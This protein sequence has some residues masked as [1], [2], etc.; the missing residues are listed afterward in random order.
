M[1]RT[2]RAYFLAWGL[3][4]KLLLVGLLGVAVIMWATAFSSRGSRFWRAQRATTAARQEQDSWLR[5]RPAIE[6]A[7]RRAASQMDP[8]KTFDSTN[9]TVVVRQ[10]ANEAGIR[11]PA[12][13]GAGAASSGQF[14]INTLR[15]TITNAEWRSFSAFYQKLQARAPY[16]A[17]TELALQPVRGNPANVMASMTVASF[18]VRR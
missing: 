14:A 12:T 16:I 11:D 9:L 7:T 8:R 3:R 4:E 17:I 13:Q 18:E 10:L 6:A 2:L 15:I 1:I 5:R